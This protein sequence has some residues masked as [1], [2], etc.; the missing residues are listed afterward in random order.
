MTL[1]LVPALLL[2]SAEPTSGIAWTRDHRRAFLEA[3]ERRQPVLLQFR[4]AG[5]ELP[6]APGAVDS[7]DISGTRASGVDRPVHD[8]RLSDCDL[9]QVDVWEK[10][11][12]AER[13]RRFQTVLVDGADPDLRVRYQVVRMPTVLLADPWGNEILRFTGYHPREAVSKALDA[14]PQD[15]APLEKAG[16]ALQKEDRDAPALVEAARF[17]EGV[18]LRQT[19]E[20]LYDLALATGYWKDDPKARREVVVA[21]GV[22]LMR[23]QRNKD[24]AKLFEDALGEDPAGAG[25]DALLYGLLA[26]RLQDGNRKAAQSA[27][28]ELQRRFPASPYTQRAGQVLAA[29]EP[30]RP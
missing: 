8:T 21:R 17:W 24:A 3:R 14:M 27:H 23:M 16:L 15:F 6:S 29:A 26:A 28:Q 19:S 9:M 12:V 22:N 5:C 7:R 1:L 13:T 4:G 10:P 18:G 20:R 11:E 2:A 30:K 25:S